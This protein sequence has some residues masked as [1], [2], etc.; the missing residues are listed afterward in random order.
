MT[1][2]REKSIVRTSII[3]IAANI[4][5]VAFKAAVGIFANSIAI[6]LDAVNNLSDALSSV[7]TIVGTKLSSKAPDKKHPYGYGRIEYITSVVIAVIVLL[8][9]VTSLRESA[10]KIFETQETD[11][12]VPSVIVI[13]AAI[14]AK[15]FIGRY[16]KSQGEKLNSQSLSAS[17]ADAL[18]DALLSAG[19]LVTAVVSMIWGLSLD[20]IMGVLISVIIIKSGIEILTETLNSIIGVRADSELTE[21]LK[22][23]INSYDAVRGTYDLTLHN[24]GPTKIMGTAHIEIDDSM[25]ARDIHRLTRTITAEVFAEFGIVLTIGVYASN[26][27][28]KFAEIKKAVDSIVSSYDEVLQI[29]GFYGD[30]DSKIV[31]FDIIVDFDSDAAAVRDKIKKEVEGKF[32]GYR[33]EV[34]L[35]SDYSD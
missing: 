19:T 18:F 8:A 15:I 34:I 21:K 33:F 2:N 17:G 27:T 28:G 25:T 23:K 5:L 14:A 31:T 7:I 9:G 24:Y 1:E 35:D 29:H 20:G 13:A 10:V 6:I 22:N 16:F 3:G 12:S 11:Y 30:D 32:P 26:N 4:I